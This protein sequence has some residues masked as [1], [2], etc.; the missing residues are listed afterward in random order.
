MSAV[1]IAQALVSAFI[2]AE[3]SNR[4]S[5]IKAATQLE[6]GAQI[7]DVMAACREALGDH[8]RSAVYLSEWLVV[9]KAAIQLGGE[10]KKELE[11]CKSY[12]SLVEFSRNLIKKD[13]PKKNGRTESTK[14]GK[15]TDN[16]LEAIE[17]KIPVGTVT[18]LKSVMEK[19]SG[20]IA[21][22]IDGDRILFDEICKLA[23]LIAQHTKD[24]ALQKWAE[25]I[26]STAGKLE[27]PA[28]AGIMQIQS[29]LPADAGKVKVQH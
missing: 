1:T 7:P 15:I 21:N 2:K 23:T 9:F 6:T 4:N 11:D 8:P 10:A 19:A 27:L 5:L 29:S 14:G 16:Q 22:R 13:K 28:P 26:V 18:Q 20:S 3:N 17:A 25:A 24:H 12:H